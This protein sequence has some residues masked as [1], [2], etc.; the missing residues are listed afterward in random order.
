[1][2][3]ALLDHKAD[4]PDTPLLSKDNL[5]KLHNCLDLD[6]KTHKGVFRRQ[7]VVGSFQFYKFY[8]VFCPWEEVPRAIECVL[9][10]L[11]G[12]VCT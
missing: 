12:L 11:S 7:W 10:D 5:L 1:F 8:R 9:Q 6:N 2:I 4:N 3:N